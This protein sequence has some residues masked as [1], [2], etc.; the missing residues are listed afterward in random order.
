MH[1]CL[2][3]HRFSTFVTSGPHF[4]GNPLNAQPTTFTNKINKSTSERVQVTKRYKEQKTSF[5]LFLQPLVNKKL[6]NMFDIVFSAVSHRPMTDV[7]RRTGSLEGR[8]RVSE[9]GSRIAARRSSQPQVLHGAESSDVQ[10]TQLTSGQP[11]FKL[12]NTPII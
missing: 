10:L 1:W 8:R 11:V 6:Y 7:I 12:G 3:D 9:G 2:L 5:F 4:Q